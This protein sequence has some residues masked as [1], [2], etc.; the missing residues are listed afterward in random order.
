MEYVLHIKALFDCLITINNEEYELVPNIPLTFLCTKDSVNISFYPTANIDQS[1]PFSFKFNP[2][3]I[4]PKKN[5]KVTIFP[6]NNYVVEAKPFFL[7]NEAILSIRAKTLTFGNAQHTLYYAKFCRE[8]LTLECDSAHIHITHTSSITSLDTK[9]SGDYLFVFAKTENEKHIV[10]VIKFSNNQYK[11]IIHEEVDKLEKDKEKIL[12]YK[13]L[14]D[15]AGH[16]IVS[17]YIFSPNFVFEKN[18]AYDGSSPEI[19]SNKELIP[20]AFFELIKLKNYKLARTY[21]T[22]ELSSALTNKSLKDYFGDFVDISQTFLKNSSQQEI[23]LLYPSSTK[24]LYNAKVF[25]IDFDDGHK[26]KNIEERF[27]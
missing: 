11:L 16:G 8:N 20:Y 13:N 1:L 18:L 27:Y 10:S 19:Q 24:N 9:T 26:I 12:T 21:L 22:H 17:T 23:S 14:H 2:Q 25:Y 7:A 3:N 6:Q 5:I 15:F 4:V